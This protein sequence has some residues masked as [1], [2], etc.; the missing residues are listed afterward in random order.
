MA[1]LHLDEVKSIGRAAARSLAGDDLEMVDAVARPDGSDEVS[2]FIT[3]RLTRDRDREAIHKL[4]LGI[5]HR[6]R[7]TL[8]ERGDEHYPYID[9][10]G[11]A[12][13]LLPLGV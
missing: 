9:L 4:F 6:V 1:E 3:Y 2:Y 11:P 12:P 8:I 7:D 5:S 10:L 13:T